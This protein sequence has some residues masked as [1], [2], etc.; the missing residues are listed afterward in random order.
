MTDDLPSALRFVLRWEGGLSD[1]PDDHGGRTMKGITQRVYDAWRKAHGLTVQ[2]VAQIGNDELADIY[3]GNYWVTSFCD[4]LRAKLNLVQFDTAVNMGSNRAV[5]ILQ[6]AVGTDVDGGFGA[7]TQ[8]ACDSCVLPTA[9]ARYCDIREQ[10]YRGFAQKPGQAKFFAGWLN[11]LNDL[12]AEAD[13]PGFHRKR[14]VN[15]PDFGDTPTIRRI[16]DLEPDQP[17]ERFS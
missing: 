7:Q 16:P 8:Q 10:L 15:N 11:R 4:R 1:D 14:G 13:V 12:R 17:L 6:E 2:D 3:R 5:R 9:V